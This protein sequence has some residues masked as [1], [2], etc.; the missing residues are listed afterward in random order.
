MLPQWGGTH[1]DS[2]ATRPAPP[3][4][5]P[6]A[7]Q[8]SLASLF[9]QQVGLSQQMLWRQDPQP[10]PSLL[11][12]SLPPSCPPSSSHRCQPDTQDRRLS[13][14]LG[15]LPFVLHQ[16]LVNGQSHLG[17]CFLQDLN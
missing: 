11:G 17:F 1:P 13:L 16:N 3:T 7:K 5:R 2:P 10:E 8:G 4:L 14:Q 9:P 12:G 15:S 6:T